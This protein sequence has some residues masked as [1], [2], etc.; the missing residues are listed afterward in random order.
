MLRPLQRAAE[1]LL[2]SCST[3]AVQSLEGSKVCEQILEARRRLPAA[4]IAHGESLLGL[5]VAVDDYLRDL[6][7]LRVPDALADG[8]CPFV[9]VDPVARPLDALTKRARR[10]LMRLADREHTHLHRREPE[11][12]RAPVVLDQDAEEALDRP[13]ERAMDHHRSVL[14]VVRPRVR[15]IEA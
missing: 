12:E 9:D 2:H 15:E 14:V 3:K 4:A 11:R 6:L 7:Q 8:L 13:E 1:I 5:P 10:F